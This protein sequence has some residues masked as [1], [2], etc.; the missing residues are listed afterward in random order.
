[1]VFSRIRRYG[2]ART[3]ASPDSV[4][5]A[6]GMA[7]DGTSFPCPCPGSKNVAIHRRVAVSCTDRPGHGQP[8]DGAAGL[9]LEG[10]KSRGDTLGGSGLC[11]LSWTHHFVY[12][13]NK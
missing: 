2:R 7:W 12:S 5:W 10:E 3:A 9:R 6:I 1:M 11:V 8:A 13:G 4:A